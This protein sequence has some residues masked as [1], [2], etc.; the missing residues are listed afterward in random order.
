MALQTDCCAVCG[1]G[2]KQLRVA[3]GGMWQM[4]TQTTNFL[5]PARDRMTTQGMVT[6]LSNLQRQKV[7]VT[8]RVRRHF[9]STL[10]QLC[11]SAF[12]QRGSH[13]AAVARQA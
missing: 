8:K 11:A 3:V 9:D 6:G 4:A 13:L 12:C 5:R 7:D 10:E 1:F 2:N